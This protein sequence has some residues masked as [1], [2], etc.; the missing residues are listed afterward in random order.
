MNNVDGNTVK[1]ILRKRGKTVRAWAKENGFGY[2]TT[3][4]VLRGINRANFGQG[5]EIA[6]RLNDLVSEDSKIA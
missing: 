6:Q 3:S 2:V 4:Q 1:H 5:R